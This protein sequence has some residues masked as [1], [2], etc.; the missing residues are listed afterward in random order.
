MSRDARD[1]LG[2]VA[3]IFVLV[4]LFIG[5]L[6]YISFRNE[7]SDDEYCRTIPMERMDKERCGLKKREQRT[8]D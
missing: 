4:M 7:K 6:A 5:A 1:V 8:E 3:G 2:I